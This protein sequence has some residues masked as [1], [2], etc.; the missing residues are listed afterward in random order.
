MKIIYLI[1]A[2]KNSKRIKNKNL[3]KLNNKTLIELTIDF[4]KKIAPLKHIIFSTDSEKM[5]KIAN[6]LGV[7]TPWLRPKNLSL[8]NTSS[9]K[10]SIHAIKWY[11]NKFNKIDAVVLFQPTSPFRSKKH[12]ENALKKFKKNPKIPLVSV[13]KVG[14]TGDK[15]LIKKNKYMTYFTNK[16]DK[17]NTFIPNGSF[18]IIEKKAL[19][20]N[21]SFYANKMNYYEMFDNLMNIDIDTP[22]DYL[23]AKKLS[24]KKIKI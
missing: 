2:R 7:K 8:D 10:T 19:I 17:V 11:E 23:M 20:K 9:Y 15:I 18:Y 3:L 4:V 12:F 13:K 1:L 21:K 14:L 5:R 22:D 16:K 24:S 6:N